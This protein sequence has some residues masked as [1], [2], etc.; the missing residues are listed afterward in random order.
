MKGD[1]LPETNHISRLCLKKTIQNGEIEWSAFLPRKEPPEDSLSVNWLEYLE[2]DTRTSEVSEL[3]NIYSRK[4]R[5]LRGTQ[6]A[7]LRVGEVKEQILKN[8]PDRRILRIL[9]DPDSR[10]NDPSHSG[11]YD[12]TPNDL[13]IGELIRQKVLEKY[14]FSS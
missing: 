10:F 5:S 3:W 7:I 4:F 11:I 14:H 6:I 2:L 8:T 1:P 12:L 13:E 9:H